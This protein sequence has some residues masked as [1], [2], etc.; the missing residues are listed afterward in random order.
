MAESEK[1]ISVEHIDVE[2]PKI[3]KK[4]LWFYPLGTVGRDMVYNMFTQF[5]YLY[6][7]Y[8]KQLT[9]SQ[10]VAITAIMVAARVFDAFNDPIMGNIIERTRSKWG[11]FKPWLLIGVLSTSIVLYLAFSSS[12]EGW[13]FVVFFG[14]IYFMYS[15]TYTMNDISYW[16]MIPALSRSG[17]SRNQF[18]SRTTLFAGVGGTLAGMLI[19]MFTAGSLQIGGNASTA[20]SVIALIIALLCPLFVLFTLFGVRENRDDMEKP[21]EKISFKLIIKTIFGNDQLRWMVLIFLLQQI[22][23]SVVIGGIG[24]NYVYFRYGYEGG[25]YSLFSTIGVAATAFLMLFY[26][27]ISRKLN[28]KAFMKI[29]CYIASAGYVLMIV[30][31]LVMPANMVGFW[32]L[33]IGYMLSAFGMYGFYLIMMISIF[34]TVE[35]N[36]L[37][38]G[39]RREGI[40]T[41]IRPFI[42]K[43]GSAVVVM[44]TSLCYLLFHVTD[45]TNQIADFE[46][47][48]NL[49]KIVNEVKNAKIDE[50][51]AKVETGQA[52]GML[53]FMTIVPFILLLLSYFLYKRFY[54]L[55]EAEYAKIVEELEARKK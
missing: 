4:N 51:I 55:D 40:I 17:D 53:L 20:Y 3:K 9:D 1:R 29:L 38:T 28:R 12:L 42:T 41:S 22:G 15:I 31:G 21:A 6:I 11:K 2:D 19:P 36:E 27:A 48:A 13:G 32:A 25:L 45:Y 5:I 7:L 44:I 33:T 37:K 52:N 10:I 43:L 50:V 39:S 49:G 18:T 14:V 35:Y 8:T 23:N 16:G 46:Q 54:K 24:A 30:A 26:P 34:N 47:Q